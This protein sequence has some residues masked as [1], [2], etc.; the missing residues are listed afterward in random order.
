AGAGSSARSYGLL[1]GGVF[2]LWS[3]RIPM[4]SPWI[5]RR[6]PA[7]TRSP[8]HMPLHAGT[9]DFMKPMAP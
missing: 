1:R 2:H 7:R 4:Q 9:R 8:A 3:L 5:R 6:S